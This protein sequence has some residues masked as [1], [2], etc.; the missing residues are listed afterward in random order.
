MWVGSKP[1]VTNLSVGW[2]QK[3]NHL[4]YYIFLQLRS[5]R[6]VSF[7]HQPLHVSEKE[8]EYE[9]FKLSPNWTADQKA[10]TEMDWSHV[11]RY[12]DHIPQLALDCNLLGSRRAVQNRP[13]R[14]P[15]N[16]ERSS[17]SPRI[18]RTVRFG[19][20][21]PQLGDTGPKVNVNKPITQYYRPGI[22]PDIVK[23]HPNSARVSLL[24]NSNLPLLPLPLLVSLCRFL[25]QLRHLTHYIRG[26]LPTADMLQN[27]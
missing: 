11:R 3:A 21:L 15:F 10:A 12:P 14:G 13:D 22:E 25:R 16:L 27:L 7:L 4:N 23:S 19:S 5:N 24:Q 6:F 2:A 8:T 1:G 20:T 18:Q 9:S 26:D 17:V